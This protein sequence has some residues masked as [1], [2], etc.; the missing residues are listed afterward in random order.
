MAQPQSASPLAGKRI[1]ILATDRFEETELTGPKAALAEAGA[2]VEVISPKAGTIQG[3]R[4]HEPGAKVTVD[5]TLDEAKS[6]DYDAVVLPGGVVN[7]DAL[8]TDERAVRFVREAF[9]MGKPVAAICHG[10]WMLIEADVVRGLTV[11][12]WPSLETDLRNAGAI[13]VDQE[14]AQETNLITSRKPADVPA[15]TRAIIE[16]VRKA[17]PAKHTVAAE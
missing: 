3:M 10:P 8:R 12:S 13:W 17:R 16:A 14:V 9:A 6:E 7:P 1:A 2:R 5:R 11:T 15:F 4:H